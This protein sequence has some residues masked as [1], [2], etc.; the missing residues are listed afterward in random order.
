MPEG[1]DNVAADAR[2]TLSALGLAAIVEARSGGQRLVLASARG[3]RL[4]G[5]DVIGEIV[6]D[7]GLELLTHGTHSHKVARWP[8]LPESLPM[9]SNGQP[10]LRPV[11]TWEEARRSLLNCATARALAGALLCLQ[12]ACCDVWQDLWLQCCGGGCVPSRSVLPLRCHGCRETAPVWVHQC[13]SAPLCGS[14]RER[15]GRG[16]PKAR[17]ALRHSGQMSSS[18]WKAIQGDLR[19]VR[20]DGVSCSGAPTAA[21]PLLLWWAALDGDSR[22]LW[23]WHHGGRGEDAVGARGNAA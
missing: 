1:D 5:V 2:H 8:R 3:P 9:M 4:D 7:Y 20:V 18:A 19:S 13:A 10:I 23:L 16:W 12:E 17:W 11:S 22:I 6:Q 15:A 21:L 14:C